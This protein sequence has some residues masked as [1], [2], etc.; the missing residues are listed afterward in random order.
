MQVE[1]YPKLQMESTWCLSNI[2]GGDYNM[3][4][5]QLLQ[6]KPAPSLIKVLSNNNKNIAE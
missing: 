1:C 3:S 6:A 2:V 5:M 4:N